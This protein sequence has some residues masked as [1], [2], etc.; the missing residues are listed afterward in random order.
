MWR[1]GAD[2]FPQDPARFFEFYV[3]ASLSN[4]PVVELAIRQDDVHKFFLVGRAMPAHIASF[5]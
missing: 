5:Q 1:D 3:I 2:C 4:D